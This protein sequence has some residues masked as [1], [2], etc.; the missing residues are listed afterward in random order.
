MHAH[1]R[2]TRT[3]GHTKAGALDCG[4]ARACRAARSDRSATRPSAPVPASGGVHSAALPPRRRTTATRTRRRLGWAS[5][6]RRSR[7]A[8]RRT[9]SS[10]GTGSFSAAGMGINGREWIRCREPRRPPHAV[11]VSVRPQIV[12][13]RGHARLIR[14]VVGV[15]MIVLSPRVDRRRLDRAGQPLVQRHAAQQVGR[16]GAGLHQRCIEQSCQVMPRSAFRD[17]DPALH[18]EP[19]AARARQLILIRPDH[20]PGRLHADGA[21]RDVESRSRSGRRLSPAPASGPRG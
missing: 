19:V 2:S 14:F 21:I 15:P 4:P 6:S 5:V 10:S 18:G 3:V 12:A 9:T 7:R 16:H 20:R 13:E 17:I 1:S 11:A 8:N